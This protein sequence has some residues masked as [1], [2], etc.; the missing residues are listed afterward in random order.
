[1]KQAKVALFNFK[2]KN[3]LSNYLT[4]KEKN[5]IYLLYIIYILNNKFMLNDNHIMD[6]VVY[7]KLN[8]FIL[9]KFNNFISCNV[10]HINQ[11]FLIILLCII[12][13]KMNKFSII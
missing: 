9:T 1:M 2:S 11:I 7:N 13:P 3:S 5:Y 4:K 12:H 6:I 8:N 10:Y